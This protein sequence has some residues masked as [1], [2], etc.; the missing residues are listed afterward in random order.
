VAQGTPAALKDRYSTD[1]L[2]VVPRDHVGVGTALREMGHAFT[3]KNDTVIVPVRDSL[4]ALQVL[5]EIEPRVASFEVIKGSM[6]M[7]FM[8][9]TGHAIR[10]EGEE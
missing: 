8:N 7:V 4:H 10:G 9:V 1:S 3:V 2:V 5:K 6:D